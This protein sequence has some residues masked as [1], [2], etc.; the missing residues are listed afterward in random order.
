[1]PP[2]TTS[3]L[4]QEANRKPRLSAREAMRCAQGLLRERG[5]ITYMRTDSVHLSEQAITA[6][7]SCVRDKYGKDHLEQGA[8]AIHHQKPAMRRRPTRPSVLRESFR[9]PEKRGWKGSIWRCTNSSGN[10]PSPARWPM[11]A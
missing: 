3:T 6:A 11:P 7:R 1:M 5:Y 10:A 9:T 2:F 8:A 4:Q